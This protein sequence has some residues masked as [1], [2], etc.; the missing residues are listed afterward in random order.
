M[1]LFC[2]GPNESY[3]NFVDYLVLLILLRA[4]FSPI[5]FNELFHPSESSDGFWTKKL[6]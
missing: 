4:V 3:D 6:F 2:R 1:E 5:I